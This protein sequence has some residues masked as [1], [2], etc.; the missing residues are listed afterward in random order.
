MMRTRVRRQ[1]YY[2]A[3]ANDVNLRD[4]TSS[5]KNANHL[6]ILRDE[7]PGNCCKKLS[8]MTRDYDVSRDYDFVIREGDDLGWLGY[9]IRRSRRIEAIS[10]LSLPE[11]RERIDAL[12]EGIARNQSIHEFHFA[13]EHSYQSFEDCILRS[14]KNLNKLGFSH[15]NIGSERA[16][17]IASTLR[18]MQHNQV[19]PNSL[20]TFL[21]HNNTI[22]DESFAVICGELKLHPQLEKLS[23][24]MN[25]IGR[26]GCM[27][28][29][30]MLSS[31]H[32]P[33]LQYLNLEGNSIDDRGLQALVVGMT[34]CI[35]LSQLVLSGNRSITA[36]GFRSLSTFFQSEN[37]SLKVVS[38]KRMNIGDDGAVALAE[39]L[40]GNKSLKQLRFVVDAAGITEVGWSAFSK[41]LHDT[42]STNNTYLSNHILKQI[43]QSDS[44]GT[45]E[46]VKSSLELNCLRN[47]QKVAMLKILGHHGVQ[48]DFDTGS[49]FRWKLKFLPLIVTW[50]ERARSV[51]SVFVDAFDEEDILEA[52]EGMKL[53]AVYKYVRG[54]PLLIIDGYNSRRTSTRLARKR[55]LNG[56]T[57]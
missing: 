26:N 25:D 28:L 19:Q 56:E 13:T 8:L 41:L 7:Q 27:A 49:L 50:L 14:D 29:G 35:N 1:C 21:I 48:L 47:K 24:Y 44:R 18:R 45:P 15:I 22:C 33:N 42:S 46:D 40:V 12:I 43:G 57:K 10:I 17:N 38:F 4:I 36:A 5:E 11:N 51:F 3:R 20:K 30:N 52:L 34:N 31:W 32:A 6:R 37:C 54:V 55:R 2:D 39:G 9:F 23:L 53:S 16:R